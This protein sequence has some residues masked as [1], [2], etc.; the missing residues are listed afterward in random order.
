MTHSIDFSAKLETNFLHQKKEKLHVRSFKNED[1]CIKKT[2]L[3]KELTAAL[4]EKL[5]REKELS[6]HQVELPLHCFFPMGTSSIA[7]FSAS[8]QPSEEV[9]KLFEKMANSLTY[10][11]QN[12]ISTTTVTL[13]G[14]S[15][16]FRDCTIEIIEYS[17]APKVFNVVFGASTMEA[18]QAFVPHA[19][20]IQR[21]LQQEH[22]EFR[23]ERLDTELRDQREDREEGQEQ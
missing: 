18:L 17:T 3:Q 12:G 11:H 22:L 7:P 19:E 14:F 2:F 23:V 10:V 15:P 16:L 6:A 13:E 9:M 5:A 1:A 20:Q 4:K 8:W 21:A